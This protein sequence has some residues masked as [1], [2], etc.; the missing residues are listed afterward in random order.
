MIDFINVIVTLQNNMS[1][2]LLSCR[3]F[4]FHFGTLYCSMRSGVV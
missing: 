4:A 2:I 3:E 1:N